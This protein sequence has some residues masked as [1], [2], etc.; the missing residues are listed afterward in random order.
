MK[1]IIKIVLLIIGAMLFLNATIL[2]LIT[3]FNFG[4]IITLAFGLAFM[5]Y[6]IYFDKINEITKVGVFKWVEYIVFAGCLFLICIITFI[7][8]YGQIDTVTYKEDAVIVLGAGIRGETVTLP[9]AYR[10]DKAIE[11]VN[12]NPKS[13]IVVSGG[14]GFQEEISEALA[15][16]KYLVN[17]GV[18]KEKI[19]REEQAT[20]T[21][22]NFIYS[23]VI[24]DKIF[25][26][27]YKTALI[28]ND[29]HIYRATQISKIVELDSTH[30]H[31]ELEWYT[32]P[33]NYLRESVAVLKLWLLR[34]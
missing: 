19:I 1:M 30:Y 29:F 22:E 23:K 12:K 9:L 11:Y 2:A 6:G 16:E 7:A 14:Q 28:T 17:K 31:A 10:L 26:R 8:I 24:L 3:N 5:L 20:S 34:R 21:Y 27:P 32:V 15:M 18:S 4:I 13:I 33:L 25:D